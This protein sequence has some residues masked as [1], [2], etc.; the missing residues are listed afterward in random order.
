MTPGAD[1]AQLRDLKKRL[2]QEVSE[3]EEENSELV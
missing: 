1:Y 3:K 2:E